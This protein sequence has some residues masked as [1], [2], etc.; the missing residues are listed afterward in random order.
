MINYMGHGSTIGWANEKL[1]TT[2]KIKSMINDKYPIFV[3]ATCDF[4]AFDQFTESGGE[5]LIWNKTGGTMALITTTRT[6]YASGNA[7]LN[8][9]LS[10][11]LFLK[12]TKDAPL[13]ISKKVM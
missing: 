10:T 12:D 9:H 2:A 13:T 3:T 6:V 8:R 7:E 1:L 4:S 5:Q 11:N